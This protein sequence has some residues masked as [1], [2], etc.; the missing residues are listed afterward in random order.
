MNAVQAPRE[1]HDG[2]IAK[3]EIW[4]TSK[5]AISSPPRVGL[6]KISYHYTLGKNRRGYSDR[7]CEPHFGHHPFMD[8]F[9]SRPI[10]KV[11]DWAQGGVAVHPGHRMHGRATSHG[12]NARS[13]TSMRRP[14]DV[15][16]CLRLCYRGLQWLG[17]GSDGKA[18]R[19]YA[20]PSPREK[21]VKLE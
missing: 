10:G 16:L 18:A 4:R 19:K 13:A 8:A 14:A 12:S 15:A 9:G 11:T 17:F 6:A 5:I 3:T 7:S 1:M 2:S 21:F 20:A